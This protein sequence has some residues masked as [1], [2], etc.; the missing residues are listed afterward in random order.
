M[1]GNTIA[2]AVHFKLSNDNS[3]FLS[4]LGFGDDN[5]LFALK[6]RNNESVQ[7]N[8]KIV[9]KALDLGT[10]INNTIHYV[11]YLGSLTSPPCLQKVQWFVLLQKLDVTQSQLDYFPV[12][13]GRDSNIR[14]LQ[15][16]N[17][18]PIKII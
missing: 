17:N 2:V 11:T 12:L 7:L 18:R 3:A 8:E 1:F 13:F 6:L 14:G 15:P 10:Y 16:L 4:A 5:P 9:S